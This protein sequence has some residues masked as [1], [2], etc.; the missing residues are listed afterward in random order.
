MALVVQMHG[1]P[2]SGKSTLARALG[3]R[4]GALVLDKDVIKAALLQSGMAEQDAA[5]AAY[6]VYFGLARSFAEQGRPLILDNP[7]FWPRVEEQ[8]LSLARFAA[9]PAVL[10]ECV[11]GD[12]EELRRRL[13]S[14]PAL[15]SQPRQPLDLARHTGAAPTLFEPRLTLD[16]LQPLGGLVAAALGYIE[17]ALGASA[18]SDGVIAETAG[19]TGGRR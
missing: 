8:W 3:S 5:P 19:G 12:R 6:D 11:C 9:S 10:I 4:L 1:E 17:H 16:T 18:V 13:S 2:G 7:V 15:A 14:R